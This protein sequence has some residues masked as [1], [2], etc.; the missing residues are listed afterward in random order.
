[1]LEW[2][3]PERQLAIPAEFRPPRATAKGLGRFFVG[4]KDELELL[5]AHHGRDPKTVDPRRPKEETSFITAVTNA[6]G[7]GKSALLDR[8]RELHG[9]KGGYILRLQTNDLTSEEAL[10]TAIRTTRGA[11]VGMILRL[12]GYAAKIGATLS[13]IPLVQAVVE[14]GKMAASELKVRLPEEVRTP[15]E[16]RI[17]LGVANSEPSA[18]GIE[19]MKVLGN[20]TDAGVIIE[21][22]EAQELGEVDRPTT[23]KLLQQL[24]DPSERAALELRSGGIVLAGLPD[25]DERLATLHK[26]RVFS[27]PL[28]PISKANVRALLATAWKEGLQGTNRQPPRTQTS[29]VEDLTEH[30]HQWTH[31][32]YSAAHAIYEIV[33]RTAK[34]APWSNVQPNDST[35]HEWFRTSAALSTSQLYDRTANLAAGYVGPDGVHEVVQLLHKNGEIQHHELLG[36]F[37]RHRQRAEMD[38]IGKVT[39]D[40]ALQRL[41]HSGLIGRERDENEGLTGRLTCPVPS[42]VN[43]LNATQGRAARTKLVKDESVPE[44]VE[45]FR[46]DGKDPTDD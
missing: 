38:P 29:I 2:S 26:S 8:F 3:A 6:P 43:Y 1:M 24:G 44:D 45:V 33:Q 7:I 10:A 22:D 21:I 37:E 40:I 13:G 9:K 16:A 30:F 23:S 18:S 19:L 11:K 12:G 25:M 39:D 5:A 35:L 36:L 4:R 20:A 28:A 14:A 41:L 42:M 27:L 15:V 17:A 31:H 32:A 34:A 46:G